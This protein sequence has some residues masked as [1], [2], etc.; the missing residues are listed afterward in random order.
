MSLVVIIIVIIMNLTTLS[1]STTI[2]V[3]NDIETVEGQLYNVF[4][5][6]H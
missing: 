3:E 2:R 6:R 5:W 1:I 4:M